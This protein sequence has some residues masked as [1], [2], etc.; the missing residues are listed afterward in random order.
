MYFCHEGYQW[1]KKGRTCRPQCSVIFIAAVTDGTFCS[2]LMVYHPNGIRPQLRM[3]LGSLE[4]VTGC[5]IWLQYQLLSEPLIYTLSIKKVYFIQPVIFQF[6]SMYWRPN[7][8]KN[9]C[10]HLLVFGTDSVQFIVK[11]VLC[12][13]LCL[14]HRFRFCT[15]KRGYNKKYNNNQVLEW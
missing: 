2:W 13:T 10:I 8:V 11:A 14:F 3:E 12:A 6:S 9:N 7:T 15:L 5:D 4:S 1:W